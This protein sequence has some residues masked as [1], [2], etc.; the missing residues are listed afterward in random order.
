MTCVVCGI[1]QGAS[2]IMVG[3]DRMR[4]VC[5]LCSISVKEAYRRVV[6]MGEVCDSV[7][8]TLANPFLT[9]VNLGDCCKML[10]QAAQCADIFRRGMKDEKG[11]NDDGSRDVP[12]VGGREEGQEDRPEKEDEG[13]GQKEGL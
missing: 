12:G 4:T 13:Q 10:Y 8:A 1:G 9:Q 2:Y 6:V 11:R 7:A 3:K 5:E